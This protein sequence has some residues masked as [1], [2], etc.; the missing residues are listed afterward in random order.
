MH[1]NSTK[2]CAPYK[3]SSAD[4]MALF[5]SLSLFRALFASFQ[6]SLL[7]FWFFASRPLPVMFHST[8]SFFSGN[9]SD[10]SQTSERHMWERDSL[11]LYVFSCSLNCYRNG[12]LLAH[13]MTC[14]T[15]FT[16]VS[17]CPPLSLPLGSL[18]N[19]KLLYPQPY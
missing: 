6:T 8:F 11:R 9:F 15:S 4:C 5:F 16:F 17:L 7:P 13:C 12:V 19:M 2:M 10:Q 18:A 3:S 14:F 1:Q